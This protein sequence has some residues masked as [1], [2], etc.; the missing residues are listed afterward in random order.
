MHIILC[1]N[2]LIYK[3]NAANAKETTGK[4]DSDEENSGIGNSVTSREPMS[5]STCTLDVVTGQNRTMNGKI[6]LNL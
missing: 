6:C 4:S 5:E 1:I 3:M 2:I